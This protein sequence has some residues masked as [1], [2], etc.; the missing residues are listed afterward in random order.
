MLDRKRPQ[1]D[2]ASVMTPP[3]NRTAPEPGELLSTEILLIGGGLAGLSLAAALGD[4]GVSVA[5]IEPMAPERMLDTGFDGRTTAIAAGSQTALETIGVWDSIGAEAEPILEIRISDGHS[6]LF[7]HYDYRLL[8]DEALGHIVENRVLRRALLSRLEGLPSVTM[9]TGTT[10]RR[11]D[12]AGPAVEA[13]TDRGIEIRAMLA[14]A[15]DG[16]NSPT[17]QAAAIDTT[18]W[19]YDQTGIVCTVAH[20]RNHRGIAQER[21]LPS[22]P[23]AILP[24]TE[25]RS[26]IVWTERTDLAPRL[27]QLDRTA[28]IEEL[29]RRFGDYLGA[30]ELVGPVFSYPL[31]LL[32]AKSYIAPRLALAGDAAHAIHPIAG[33]GLNIGL[34]DVAVLAEQIVDTLRL[35]LDPGAPAMLERYERLRR[36]DNTLMLAAT[37]GLNRLFSNNIAPVRTARDLG[38]AAVDRMPGLKKIFMGHAMGQLGDLPRLVR[39]ER[40]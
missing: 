17:R 39:G 25:R 6:P 36:F 20:E 27:L 34:R 30:L 10:I 2:C 31:G 3:P 22:G 29:A 24:M 18:S 12:R 37:D 16:R 4:A 26:S 9:L 7:L 19:R 32:H 21:F 33:Q 38:L 8:G 1:R 11:L 5:V 40:L 15:T 14:I 35:G 13:E 23:F 28:F